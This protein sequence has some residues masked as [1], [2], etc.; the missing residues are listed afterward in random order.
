V[1]SAEFIAAEE[2]HRQRGYWWSP[3]GSAIA[4]SAPMPRRWRRGTSPIQRIRRR[5]TAHRYPAAGTDN[6]TVTL[7]VLS[8]DGGAVQVQWDADAFPYL[9][10]VAWPAD[11]QL[12]VTVQ[13]R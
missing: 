7:H 5:A 11:K 12:L 3:D 1:G 13:S 6:A 9:A 2:M 10:D 8:L 4:S